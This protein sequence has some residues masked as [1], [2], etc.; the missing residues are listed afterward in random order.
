M[1]VELAFGVAGGIILVGV[2]SS[3]LSKRFGIPDIPVLIFLGVVLGPVSGTIQ[4]DTLSSLAPVFAALA[5]TV[6][7]FEGGIHL[8]ISRV[9]S[10]AGRAV[11]LALSGFALS[12]LVVGL[13]FSFFLHWPLPVALLLGSTVGGSSSVVVFSLLRRMGAP[14]RVG[15]LLSLESALTDVLVIVVTTSLVHLVVGSVGTNYP[16]VIGGIFQ[17]FATGAAIG[18]VGG[19]VWLKMLDRMNDEPYKDIAT[20]GFL[21]GAYALAV[22]F[23]GSG[24][25]SALIIGLVIGNGSEV[26]KLL[27]LDP[28]LP[29]EG[30][31]RRFHEQVSFA[32]RT[33]FFVYLGLY[34]NF[35]SPFLIVVGGLASLILFGAR[36]LA[37]L[38]STVGD[39]VLR[40]DSWMMTVQYP[41]GLAAAVMA[42]G[43]LVAAFPFSGQ[44]V[45]VVLSVI[46]WTVVSSSLMV[47]LLPSQL[48]IGLSMPRFPWSTRPGVSKKGDRSGGVEGFR[49]AVRRAAINSVREARPD[50]EVVDESFGGFEPLMAFTD[51][52]QSFVFDALN[53]YE[54]TTKLPEKVNRCLVAR[55]EGELGFVIDDFTAFRL[56]PRLLLIE[57]YCDRSPS[58]GFKV[59]LYALDP[60]LRDRLVPLRQLR[61]SLLAPAPK[62]GW[63][64]G[65]VGSLQR[66]T[67]RLR[68]QRRQTGQG[69][70]AQDP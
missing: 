66:T 24:A 51:G 18:A 56:L 64:R 29:V 1:G 13:V 59:R 61:S 39:S 36:Y 50:M 53:G 19:V 7:L 47:A 34:F 15:A 26:R 17:T 68:Q 69:Q 6:I 44:L 54:Q 3:L 2:V 65:V 25:I 55:L 21:L 31:S 22:T 49:Q 45:D 23:N 33:F 12:M 27:R 43:F 52:T 5:V 11:V 41:R 38:G 8:R 14:E 70:P 37:V 20:I 16:L 32:L 60:H 67:L 40:M 48:A 28:G 62:K 4:V 9:V 57:E 35:Q 10:Q 58:L 46:I 42:Q 30:I 63:F